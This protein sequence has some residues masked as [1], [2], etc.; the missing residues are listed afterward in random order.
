MVRCPDKDLFGPDRRVLAVGCGRNDVLVP[1]PQAL[2]AIVEQD[3]RY[4]GGVR[5]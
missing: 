4:C 1:R 5:D 3:M 2:F